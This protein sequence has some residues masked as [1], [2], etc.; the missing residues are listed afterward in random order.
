MARADLLAVPALGRADALRQHLGTPPHTSIS[1]K[2]SPTLSL[3]LD[4]KALGRTSVAIETTLRNGNPSVWLEATPGQ[5]HFHM[6]TVHP[7]DEQQLASL[8]RET[9]A[10]N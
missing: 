9:L 4:E 8:V 3:T 1:A 10:S 2:D 5:L 6:Y 7:G